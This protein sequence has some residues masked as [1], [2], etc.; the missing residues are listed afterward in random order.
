MKFQDYLEK[1]REIASTEK[2]VL[3]S[4]DRFDDIEIG[5]VGLAV[6]NALE[7]LSNILPSRNYRFKHSEMTRNVWWDQTY[8]VQ[9]IL[10]SEAAA[11]IC[12]AKGLG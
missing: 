4:L 10:E 6:P 8:G 7:G 12:A 2:S 3:E 1:T 11:L 9:S 5:S